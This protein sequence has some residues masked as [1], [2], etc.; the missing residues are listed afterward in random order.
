MF[1]DTF[2]IAPFSNMSCKYSGQNMKYA[3]LVYYGCC[4]TLPQLWL[5]TKE[6]NFLAV[7]EAVS[8]TWVC[9]G[10]GHDVEKAALPVAACSP[11]LWP[12]HFFLS[13]SLIP[14]LSSLSLLSVSLKGTL[15]IAI[16]A[17]YVIQVNLTLFRS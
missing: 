2:W 3:I 12:C 9:L 1:Y 10:Q 4:I 16:R 14:V 7:L 13:T 11:R 8:Q 15:V 6:I 5:K 17:N